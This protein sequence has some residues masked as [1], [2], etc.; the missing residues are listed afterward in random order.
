MTIVTAGWLLN[1]LD[2]EVSLVRDFLKKWEISHC[3]IIQT[4]AILLAKYS[5]KLNPILLFKVT[6]HGNSTKTLFE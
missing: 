1:Q 6:K 2:L 5:S 3:I 4:V